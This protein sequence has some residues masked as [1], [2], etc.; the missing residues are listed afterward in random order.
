MKF[1]CVFPF[2]I[3]DPKLKV[4]LIVPNMFIHFS[5]HINFTRWS[6]K[7]AHA[8]I[9]LIELHC[10]DRSCLGKIIKEDEKNKKPN[11]N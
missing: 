1:S 4:T 9:H 3:I 5:S 8:H 6:V 2:I 10:N 11:R 7:E